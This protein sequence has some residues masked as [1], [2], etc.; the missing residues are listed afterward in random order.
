MDVR[1]A[2]D[3]RCVRVLRK[4]DGILDHHMEREAKRHVELYLLFGRKILKEKKEALRRI[5]I[6]EAVWEKVI[7]IVLKLRIMH[8]N[9]LIRLP[10]AHFDIEN[11]EISEAVIDKFT[12]D[13]IRLF[14]GG[15]FMRKLKQCSHLP[16]FHAIMGTQNHFYS[17]FQIKESA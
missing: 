2:L 1:D 11:H 7:Y 13:L 8:G 17:Y 9:L 12:D 5:L 10:G 6:A 16:L 15:K 4:L 14:V 3:S